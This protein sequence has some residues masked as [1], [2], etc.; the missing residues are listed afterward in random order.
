MLA[1]V[2]RLNRKE[3]GIE[4]INSFPGPEKLAFGRYV[5]DAISIHFPSGAS[6]SGIPPGIDEACVS[7]SCSR[8]VYRI[9]PFSR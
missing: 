9:S 6:L 1:C 7:V 5:L 3:F 2:V 4:M 8:M